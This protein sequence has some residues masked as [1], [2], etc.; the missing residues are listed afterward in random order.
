VHGGDIRSNE[1]TYPGWHQGYAQA[2][3]PANYSVTEDGLKLTNESQVIY[4]YPTG[5][6]PTDLASLV[7]GIS[8]TTDENTDPAYFQIPLNYGTTLQSFTT[9]RPYAP[10]KG[11]NTATPD[12]QWVS[13]R[14]ID[15]STDAPDGVAANT[16]VAFSDLITALGTPVKI[17]GFGVLTEPNTS[18]VVTGLTFG[19]STYAFAA[20][21]SATVAGDAKV[22]STLTAS[23]AGWPVGTTFS[24]EWYY[25]GGQFGG[26]IDGATSST[27]TLTDA[28]VGVQVGV[29]VTANTA[30]FASSEVHSTNMTDWVVAPQKP[31]DP[32][33]V[34]NSD[35]LPAYLAAQGVTPDTAASAGL[36]SGL[37]ASKGYTA[38]VD[39][40]GRDSYVDVY[41]YSAPVFVGTFPVV[42]GVAQITLSPAVLAQLAAGTHTLVITGQSSAT[43]QAVGFTVLAS[44]SVA[45]LAD[46]GSDTALPAA[47]AVLLLLLGGGLLVARRR[48]GMRA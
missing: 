37:D 29:I 27:Y 19:G 14:A 47:I 42:N 30:G 13:S 48:L 15:P 7:S 43:V 4:G 5:T 33:P 34:A 40:N 25:S 38:K 10:T 23:T 41:A 20:E 11:A 17:L 18:S 28:E 3:T 45:A 2:T 32:A 9:L 26:P 1:A 6:G 16:P 31:A 22:G 36:P 39:W 46:T 44:V 35:A 12:Q 21:G 8:W 24:Y